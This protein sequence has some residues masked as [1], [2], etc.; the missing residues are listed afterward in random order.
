M[1]STRIF[2]RIIK[3]V[4]EKSKI[5]PGDVAGVVLDGQMG[6]IIGIDKDFNSLT[7]LDM[8]LDIR[9]EKYNTYI[10]EKY[11]EL[12]ARR[13]FGSPQNGPKIMW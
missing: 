6:G 13:T 9:S 7:G 10:H 5:N 2:L 12:I 3:E 4:L 11:G 1:V 8:G